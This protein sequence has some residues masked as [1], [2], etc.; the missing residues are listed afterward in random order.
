MGF[1]TVLVFVTGLLLVL[2]GLFM[3][4]L[5]KDMKKREQLREGTVGLNTG[6]L[7]TQMVFAAVSLF[8]SVIVTSMSFGG[9]GGKNAGAAYATFTGIGA[10]SLAIATVIMASNHKEL[11]SKELLEIDTRNCMRETYLELIKGIM[12]TCMIGSTIAL[13]DALAVGTTAYSNRDQSVK[14]ASKVQK[15]VAVKSAS[16]PKQRSRQ[17]EMVPLK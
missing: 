5:Q 2:D 16:N 15:P 6:S 11:E 12:T 17:M 8:M 4:K 3:K 14:P 7:T 9:S 10:G 13:V 1:F